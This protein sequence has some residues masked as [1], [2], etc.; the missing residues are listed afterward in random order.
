[1]LTSIRI[2]HIGSSYHLIDSAKIRVVFGLNVENSPCTDSAEPLYNWIR[3]VLR[4][5]HNSRTLTTLVTN[6][7]PLEHEA[8]VAELCFPAVHQLCIGSNDYWQVT[9]QSP[10]LPSLEELVVRGEGSWPSIRPMVMTYPSVWSVEC[11]SHF[12]GVFL[13]QHT[14]KLRRVGLEA[15][16]FRRDMCTCLPDSVTE[17]VLSCGRGTESVNVETYLLGI[18]LSLAGDFR[19]MDLTQGPCVQRIYLEDPS[20]FAR[21][22]WLGPKEDRLLACMDSHGRWAT[23]PTAFKILVANFPSLECIAIR[24]APFGGIVHEFD[25]TAYRKTAENTLIRLP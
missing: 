18:Q 9:L 8:R 19:S 1:V 11:D 6:V 25:A 7:E 15:D 16:H 17:L 14:G 21:K 10:K 20:F 13:G 4:A 23:T 2:L 5:F 12:L 22:P 24:H 3:S